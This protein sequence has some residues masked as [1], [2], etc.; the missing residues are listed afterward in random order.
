MQR[1]STSI[2]KQALLY[3]FIVG[4]ALF[5]LGLIALTFLRSRG[6]PYA[7][8][9]SLD[10]WQQADAPLGF[11]TPHSEPA[12]FDSRFLSLSAF[13]L[14]RLPT[15]TQM[16]HPMGTRI[17][18]LTYNAQPFKENNEK[19]GGPHTGDDI[20]GI[21]GMNTDLGDPIYA[22]ASGLVVYRGEPSSEWGKII[23]TA[24]KNPQGEVRQIMYAHLQ[25]SQA[26]LGEVVTRGDQIGTNGTANLNY[27]AHLHLEM[28]DTR[29]VWIGAGYLKRPSE[30]ICPTTVIKK[31][32]HPD[33]QH[34]YTAPHQILKKNQLTQMRDNISIKHS[35]KKN[36]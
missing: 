8:L 25:H 14:A 33:P 11:P 20:N 16:T 28:R 13:D 24:H 5:I 26:A 1:L 22:I 12:P 4:L 34:L 32:S 18:A 23:I 35:N 9:K 17:G 19:R 7:P 10:T 27:P 6:E 21:G 3:C 15:A 30:H 2:N 29:A 36:N 31:W